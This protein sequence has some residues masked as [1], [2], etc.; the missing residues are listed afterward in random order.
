MI[1]IMPLAL[2]AA[3]LG[4]SPV[5]AQSFQ[6]FA[7]E[8]TEILVDQFNAGPAVR[9][10]DFVFISG[11]VG[12]IPGDVERT[13]EAYE[14]AIR[15]TFRRVGVVLNAAGAEWEDVIEMT[16]FHVDMAEHQDIF[17]D[18]RAEFFPQAPFPAW[19]GIGVERLWIEPLFVEIRVVA[20]TG[21]T[22]VTDGSAEN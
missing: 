15:D 7:P 16:T 12:G 3:L 20:Y 21:A 8:G 1:R 4:A 2:G 6:M 19:T 9:A 18:V 11:V 17:R 22:P 10:G 5:S 13:P 14:L